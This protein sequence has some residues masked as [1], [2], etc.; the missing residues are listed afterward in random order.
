MKAADH[1]QKAEKLSAACAGSRKGATMASETERVQ[2]RH[3]FWKMARF[4]AY[5]GLFT[6]GIAPLIAYCAIPSKLMWVS[7]DAWHLLLVL[8]G[9]FA[10]GFLTMLCALLDFVGFKKKWML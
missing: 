9:C 1:F 3:E 4:S 7:Q 8:L 6:A 5:T 10:L 2:H